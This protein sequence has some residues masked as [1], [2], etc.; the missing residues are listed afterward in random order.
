MFN[1]SEAYL[2]NFISIRQEEIGNQENTAK[3]KE[4]FENNAQAGEYGNNETDARSKA[5]Q[6]GYGTPTQSTPQYKQTSQSTPEAP[7]VVETAQAMQGAP[8]V[9]EPQQTVDVAQVSPQSTP[10][11]PERV[12]TPQR[13][14]VAQVTSQTQ[15]EA[16]RTDAPQSTPV[17]GDP[18]SSSGKEFKDV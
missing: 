15:V 18:T 14:D 16:P 7:R 12:E 9:R 8:E 10:V 1:S 17:A 11:A 5:Y 4:K 2:D 6:G 3:L 13:V